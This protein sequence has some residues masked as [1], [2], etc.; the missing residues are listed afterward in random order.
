MFRGAR[1]GPDAGQI[2]DAAGG[3]G[4][5]DHCSGLG[6]GRALSGLERQLAARMD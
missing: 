4:T 3:V 6:D 1:C 2:P 5:E